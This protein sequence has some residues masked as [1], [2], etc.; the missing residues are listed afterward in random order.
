MHQIRVL[1][2]DD[3]AIFRQGL[4]RLLA[5]DP[6]IVVVGEAKDRLDVVEQAERAALRT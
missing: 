1:L 2:A 6:Q 4:R 5:T 3:N